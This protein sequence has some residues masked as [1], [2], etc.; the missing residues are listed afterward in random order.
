MSNY[1]NLHHCRASI[2]NAEVELQQAR[3]YL[4]GVSADA[5]SYPQSSPRRGS[6]PHTEVCRR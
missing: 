2:D 3:A 6:R 1:D 4:D 5:G